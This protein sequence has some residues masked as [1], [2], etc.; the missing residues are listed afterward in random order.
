MIIQEE[1]FIL[2]PTKNSYNDFDLELLYLVKPKGKEAHSEFKVAAYGV[3]LEH[4]MKLIINYRIQKKVRDQAITMK[5]YLLLYKKELAFVN[6]FI[7]ECVSN[8]E[9]SLDEILTKSASSSPMIM[10]STGEDVAS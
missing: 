9:S 7:K 5:Q 2:T 6:N 4:A 10:E 3:K 8:E 1:D